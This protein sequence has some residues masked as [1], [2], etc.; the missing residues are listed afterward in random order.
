MCAKV[1]GVGSEIVLLKRP[2][3]DQMKAGVKI[4]AAFQPIWMFRTGRTSD[5]M[6]SG[7][8]DQELGSG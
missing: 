5:G 2:R 1:Q 4:G 7:K 8:Q 3:L 6:E